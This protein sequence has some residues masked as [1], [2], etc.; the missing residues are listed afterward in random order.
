MYGPLSE[1]ERF[2]ERNAV[3]AN[4]LS[5]RLKEHLSGFESKFSAMI[6]QSHNLRV[7]VL[8]YH[9]VNA[10]INIMLEFTFSKY[11]YFG[12]VFLSVDQY[13]YVISHELG[14]LSF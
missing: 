11:F 1:R 3:S 8:D 12:L 14:I 9:S 7:E 5:C 6:L 4:L 10:D 2:A 13:D